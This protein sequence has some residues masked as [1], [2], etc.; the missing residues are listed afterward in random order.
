MNDPTWLHGGAPTSSRPPLLLSSSADAATGNQSDE[1]AEDAMPVRG[2]WGRNLPTCGIS[3]GFGV[4]RRR[5]CF[6]P[7]S[8]TPEAKPYSITFPLANE[9]MRGSWA[10]SGPMN[11]AVPILPL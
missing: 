1:A 10:F 11:C 7:M 8:V 5:E 2:V 6:N 3:G 9:F 4:T